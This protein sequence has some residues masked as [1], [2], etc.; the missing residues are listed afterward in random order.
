[1]TAARQRDAERSRNAILD[2]AEAAFA[3]HGYEGTT[4]SDICA[5]AG[6]SRGLPTYLF[7]SKEELYRAVVS[8]A[9]NNL[10]ETV[11][12]PLRETAAKSSLKKTLQHA[13]SRY[14][15]YLA[16]NRRVVRLLQWEMLAADSPDRPYAPSTELFRETLEILEPVFQREGF[17]KGDARSALASIVSLCFFPFTSGFYANLAG[18]PSAPDTDVAKLQATVLR[19]LSKG[20]LS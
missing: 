6:V 18:W 13:V 12:E 19:L 1:M 3:E 9:A 15:R 7:G 4:F 10:R 8:R 2:A 5:E 14:L 17:S 11:I 16:N 20:L